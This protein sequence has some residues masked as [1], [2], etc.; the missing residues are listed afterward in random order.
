[1]LFMPFQILGFW[2]RSLLALLILG[3]GI[4]LLVEWYNHRQ[5]TEPAA[6]VQTESQPD[7]GA[8]SSDEQSVRIVP[9]RFGLN[10][11]TAFL[12]GGLALIVWSFGGWTIRPLLRRPAPDEPN[13]IHDGEIRRLRRPDGTELQVEIYGPPDG[14]PILFTHGWSLDSNEWYYT[15][16][17]LS[18]NHQLI[19]W[20]LPGLGKSS[21]PANNDW[22]LEKLAGDLDAVLTLAGD[23]PAILVG[24][25][26]G[27]M[28]ILTFCR[29]FPQ[30]L[31]SR[32]CGLVLAHTTYTNPVKTTSLAGLYTALQKPV[33]EPLCHLIVWLAPLVWVMNILS[34]LNGSAHRSTERSSFSGQESRGQLNF[35]TRYYVKAWPGVVARG[36]LAMFR[37][38]ATATLA[39]IPLPTLVVT[40]DQD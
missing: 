25:S 30:A 1:M 38:E 2:L 34:Y 27:G 31:G 5:I 32:I 3:S 15:K 22:S 24:H 7:A 29:L 20:D 19:V 11:E 37:Y 39:A 28:I 14:V 17:E 8:R 12:L 9:W 36:M 13:E 23:R 6:Q 16:K 21:R 26:I 10:R 18:R 40:G 4:Y 33:L 35:I